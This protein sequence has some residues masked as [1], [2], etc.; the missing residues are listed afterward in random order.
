MHSTCYLKSMRPKIFTH[1]VTLLRFCGE[2]SIKM[3][4]EYSN[5]V[6]ALILTVWKNGNMRLEIEGKGKSKWT[7]R[8]STNT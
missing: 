8:S 2:C 4:D 5:S 7:L 1:Y 6:V 3:Q